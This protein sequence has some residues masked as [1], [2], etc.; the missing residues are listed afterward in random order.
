MPV[1]VTF[2]HQV[3]Q[4]EVICVSEEPKMTIT[5]DTTVSTTQLAM[6]L[7]ITARR[8][9]QLTQDGTFQTETRGRFILADNVQRYITFVTGNQMSEEEKKIEIQRRRSEAKL[10]TS[11]AIVAHMEAEELRGNMH[12]SEDVSAITE[13][14]V[15]TIRAMLTALPGR[16][17][18]PVSKAESA[19]ECSVIIRDGVY[20]VMEELAKYSYDPAKYEQLVRE[21]R[22]WSERIEQ[23]ADEDN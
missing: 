17:A 12:R 2:S 13:D 7:G 18:V 9:Q 11:K 3:Q 21:R 4:L 8:V 15:K 20:A 10:K 16:L 5:D 23:D 22:E 19:E 14:M 1:S 6:V